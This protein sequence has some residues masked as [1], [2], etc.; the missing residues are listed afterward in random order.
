[1][2]TRPRMLVTGATGTI[3][4]EVVRRY[5][6]TYRVFALGHSEL[7]L[8]RLLEKFPGLDGRLYSAEDAVST[9]AAVRWAEP[10]VVVHAAA[11]KH[12]DF[13]ERQPGRTVRANLLGSLN[14]LDACLGVPV[15]VGIS[16]D[17]AACP[18]NVY[19][20]TKRLMEDCFVEAGRTACRFG[21][22]AW[23]AG[24]VLPI[25]RARAE[26]GQPLLVTHP[27]MRRF[28]FTVGEAVDL[29]GTAIELAQAGQAGF[30]LTRR[31]RHVRIVELAR[32]LSDRVQFTGR[33]PGEQFDEWMVSDD[34]AA[35]TIAL[36]NDLLTV[37]KEP[38]LTPALSCGYGTHNAPE[39]ND[40]GITHI[41]E[42]HID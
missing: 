26:A 31:L 12:V 20:Q 27:D 30:V 35:R 6:S 1:M 11:V 21:N 39:L 41:M 29:I 36:Q 3:G 38:P 13:S 9:W 5:S 33:Q 34:E 42:A 24:S 14:L 28:V 25:W 22:V 18:R 19:G 40:A 7:R 8:R 37:R 16:S 32:R 10:D 15:V 23:S 17:K 2:T 4:R